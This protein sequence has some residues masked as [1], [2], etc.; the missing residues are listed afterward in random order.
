LE[1]F[2]LADVPNDIQNWSENFALAGYDTGSGIGVFLHIGRWRKDLSLWRQMVVIALPDGVFLINR[3]V[4]NALA[5]ASG[6]G[7]PNLAM[8]VVEDGS[9]QIWSFLGGARRISGEVL[10]TALPS[11]GPLDYLSFELDFKS[12][13]PVWQLGAGTSSAFAGHGHDEQIGR[14]TGFIKI[15]DETTAID[16]QFNRDHSR[17]PRLMKQ[18]FIRHIWFQ[19]IFE[20]GMK[21]Y[22]YEAHEM[23]EVTATFSQAAVVIGGAMLPARLTLHDPLPSGDALAHIFAPVGFSF[24]YEG[25][26]LAGRAVSFPTS[27]Y[28]SSTAPWEPYLGVGQIGGTPVRRVMEQSVLYRLQDGTPGYGHMERTLPGRLVH[29]DELS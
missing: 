29:D 24:A 22:A 4:G 19:G 14:V 9:R 7:G 26:V 18:D 28:Q 23:D 10:S 11:D 15:S 3:A 1:D 27:S 21:F 13:L 6:P 8:R 16:S 25:G 20:N 12:T 17:G 2:P 5:S